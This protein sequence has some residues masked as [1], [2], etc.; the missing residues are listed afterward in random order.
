LVAGSVA[1][2]LAIALT[3]KKSGTAAPR[4]PVSFPRHPHR[5]LEPWTT[6]N[7]G[8]V[9]EQYPQ[10]YY[11]DITYICVAGKAVFGDRTLKNWIAHNS[12]ALTCGTGKTWGDG[13]TPIEAAHLIGAENLTLDGVYHSPRSGTWYGSES[14]VKQWAAYL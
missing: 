2:T 11:P 6:N 8:F 1:F 12:Y 10:A 7:L 14:I 3:T 13:I 4:L 9:N 5:S